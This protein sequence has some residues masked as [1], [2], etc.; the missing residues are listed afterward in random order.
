[1]TTAREEKE[2]L[3]VYRDA[4]QTLAK[5]RIANIHPNTTQFCSGY[6]LGLFRALSLMEDTPW[7]TCWDIQ[8]EARATAGTW[9]AEKS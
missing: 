1:M 5:H 2:L 8:N 4:E 7:Q 3:R 6:A 9:W